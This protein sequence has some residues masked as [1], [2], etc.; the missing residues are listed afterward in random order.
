MSCSLQENQTTFSGTALQVLIFR[1]PASK[2]SIPPP[3]GPP[4]IEAKR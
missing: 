1:T 3:N 2:C 4:I